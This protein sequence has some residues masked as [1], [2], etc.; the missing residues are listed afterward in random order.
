MTN[1]E[2]RNESE[3]ESF[4][5]LHEDRYL[6]ISED[7]DLVTVALQCVWHSWTYQY[8]L[9]CPIHLLL[10]VKVLNWWQH[11]ISSFV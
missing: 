9:L 1:D 4:F 8:P 11:L 3:W 5:G 6:T 7:D 10:T 2:D